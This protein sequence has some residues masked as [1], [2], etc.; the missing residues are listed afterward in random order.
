MV[1]GYK[2]LCLSGQFGSQ[3]PSSQWSASSWPLDRHKHSKSGHLSQLTE[4][5]FKGQRQN[6]RELIDP[7][8]WASTNGTELY[9][10]WVSIAS[11]NVVF[12]YKNQD[13]GQANG[14]PGVSNLCHSLFEVLLPPPNA[15]KTHS[16]KYVNLRTFNIDINIMGWIQT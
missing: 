10:T 1:F 7:K 6:L 8:V 11:F 14:A 5:Q 13:R 15:R 16:G 3:S 4:L 9:C 2:W 12:F